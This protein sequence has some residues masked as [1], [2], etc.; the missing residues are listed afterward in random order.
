[1]KGKEIIY[2]RSTH[3]IL[4]GNFL[5]FN[6][7]LHEVMLYRKFWVQP[8]KQARSNG[9][10]VSFAREACQLERGQV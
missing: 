6:I 7:F 2:G 3:Y 10:R 9:S 5:Y 1:M 8:F 4:C